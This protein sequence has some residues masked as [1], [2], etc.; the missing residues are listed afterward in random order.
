MSKEKPECLI[1]SQIIVRSVCSNE[2]Q[3]EL[4]KTHR[5]E[6]D[7]IWAQEQGKRREK[8]YNRNILN[9]ATIEQEASGRE[10]TLNCHPIEYCH[11]LAQKNGLDLGLTPLAVSGIVFYQ[12]GEEKFFFIGKRSEVVTQYPGR[13]EFIPSGSIDADLLAGREAGD[14]SKQLLVELHE[15]LGILAEEVK[16]LTPFCLIF[17]K[18][19]RVYDIGIEVEVENS[20]RIK[21]QEYTS[22]QRI[23][24]N[25]ISEYF[26][27][28]QV[29]PT[30]RILLNAW[31]GLRGESAK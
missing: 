26:K 11:Y 24:M 25:E 18:K 21:I 13:Y 19:D 28:H 15:E 22:L 10:L 31:C 30:S 5:G 20:K 17:D 4:I 8:L 1:A 29:V 7:R 16:S 23:S 9:L 6:I 3:L 14:F 12:D 2:A 27:G